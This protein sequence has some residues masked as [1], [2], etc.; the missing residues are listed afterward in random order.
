MIT[1]GILVFMGVALLFAKLP[2]RRMLMLLH[3]DLKLD[4]AV[5]VVVLAVHWGT[6]SG[7][8]AASVCG[9]LCSIFTSS[10]KRLLG[11]IHA[12][13]YYPGIIRL[14]PLGSRPL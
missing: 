14:Y 2:R 9:V 6:F 3:H 13:R 7:V 5:T 10:L 8:M 4:I 12:G 11:S 1:T